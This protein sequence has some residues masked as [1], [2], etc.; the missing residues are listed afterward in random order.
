VLLSVGHIG[1]IALNTY[2]FWGG[3][4]GIAYGAKKGSIKP[5]LSHILE[6]DEK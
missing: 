3:T 1:V 6:I 5:P 2:L 4:L